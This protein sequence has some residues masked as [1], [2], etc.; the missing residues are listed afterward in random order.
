MNFDFC[1]RACYDVSILSGLML[2]CT[3]QIMTKSSYGEI[4]CREVAPVLQLDRYAPVLRTSI[5]F[6]LPLHTGK[7]ICSGMPYSNVGPCTYQLIIFPLLATKISNSRFEMRMFILI[8]TRHYMRQRVW[9]LILGSL[10]HFGHYAFSM[11][12]PI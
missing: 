1:R 6:P 9:Y 7:Y 3:L 11:I 12:R 8:T 5:K 4:G 2:T 10:T